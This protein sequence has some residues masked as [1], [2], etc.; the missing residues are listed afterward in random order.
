MPEISLLLLFL[1]I[2]KIKADGRWQ[3]TPQS[4]T[5]PSKKWLVSASVPVRVQKREIRR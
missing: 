2:C 5:Q 4:N 3:I 1:L